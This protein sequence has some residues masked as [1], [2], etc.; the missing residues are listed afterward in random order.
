MQ[1]QGNQMLRNAW[2]NQ[3]NNVNKTSVNRPNPG[4]MDSYNN[5]INMTMNKNQCDVFNTR[6]PVPDKK[7]ANPNNFSHF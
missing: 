2:D 7:L 3:H 6:E 1:G 4:G 5:Y